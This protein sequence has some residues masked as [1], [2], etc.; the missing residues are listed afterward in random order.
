[1]QLPKGWTIETGG[2]YAGFCFRAYDPQ[3]PDAQ[4]FFYG[5]LGPYF[6]SQEG[7]DGYLAMS[8]GNDYL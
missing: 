7:K 6:K 4:I 1:M 8:G 2:A 5:E 3:N